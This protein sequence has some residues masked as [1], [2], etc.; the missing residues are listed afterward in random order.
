MPTRATPLALLALTAATGGS[1]WAARTASPARRSKAA[2]RG[3]SRSAPGAAAGAIAATAA[4]SA[5][6]RTRS[7]SFRWNASPAIA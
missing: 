1:A 7:R 2:Y 5:R 6:A 3:P 4:G